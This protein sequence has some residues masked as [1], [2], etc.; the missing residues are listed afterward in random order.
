MTKTEQTRLMTWRLKVLQRAGEA[1]RTVARTCRHFGISRQT[2]YKWKQRFDEHGEAGL[3]RS[4]ATA[5]PIAPAPPRRRSS[6]RSSTCGRT[7][8]SGR[9]RSPTT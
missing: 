1:P 2:F 3:V 5:A 6:A 7:T 9:A 8:T 4:P